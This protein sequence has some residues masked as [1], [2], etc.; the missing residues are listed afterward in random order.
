MLMAGCRWLHQN[1][2]PLT[3]RCYCTGVILRRTRVAPD[4]S[5]CVTMG[6]IKLDNL[7]S[8]VEK[9]LPGFVLD[10]DCMTI[11]TEQVFEQEETSES[12]Y[13]NWTDGTLVI[14]TECFSWEKAMDA[15]S[16]TYSLAIAL[17]QT[18]C[19]AVDV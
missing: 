17:G 9:G 12:A 18:A 16:R 3:Q 1:P 15:G 19:R 4:A 14:Y 10:E 6:T 5:H 7:F 13:R 2:M 8:C 11:P